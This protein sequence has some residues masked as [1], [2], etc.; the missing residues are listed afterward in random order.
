MFR[1][2]RVVFRKICRLNLVVL[3]IEYTI[4]FRKNKWL[5]QRKGNDLELLIFYPPLSCTIKCY[6][7]RFS[8]LCKLFIY[9][10]IQLKH[11]GV[12][13]TII[14]AWR[15]LWNWLRWGLFSVHNGRNSRNVNVAGMCDCVKLS[16]SLTHSHTSAIL[17]FLLYQPPWAGIWTPSQL[18]PPWQQNM[19]PLH[20]K[21]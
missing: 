10:S 3:Y 15:S 13:C 9:L 19:L 17:K 7:G 8:S 18:V 4:M 11:F 1:I 2:R 20:R 21:R 16:D 14:N 12:T 6:I 5:R